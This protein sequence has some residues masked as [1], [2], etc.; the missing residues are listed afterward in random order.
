M[1][2]VRC[3]V[4]RVRCKVYCV[5]CKVYYGRCKV[6]CVR[7]K[8]YCVRCKV[9]SIVILFVCL[10]SLLLCDAGDLPGK[11]LDQSSRLLPGIQGQLRHEGRY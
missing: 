1:Y 5:S 7:C 8:V 3:K 9:A 10:E 11:H 4:Y 2:F 6:Y